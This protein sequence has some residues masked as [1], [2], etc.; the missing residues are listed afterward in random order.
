MKICSW[1]KA[2]MSG[3]EDLETY[4]CEV[5][6]IKERWHACDMLTQI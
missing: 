3:F 2:G 4:G 5:L 1:C 6:S